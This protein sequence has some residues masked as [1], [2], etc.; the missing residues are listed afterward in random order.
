MVN[1][2]KSLNV[3]ER[4]NR[5]KDKTTRVLNRCRR[6]LQQNLASSH[7]KSNEETSNRTGVN[8]VRA[9]YDKVI[10]NRIL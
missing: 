10:A 7:D 2:C 9:I 3:I 5:S 1:T 4:I 6:N 8:I